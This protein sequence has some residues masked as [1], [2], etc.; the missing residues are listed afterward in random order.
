MYFSL[1]L[2]VPRTNKRSKSNRFRAFIPRRYTRDT[3]LRRDVFLLL[4]LFRRASGVQSF[5]LFSTNIVKNR[6]SRESTSADDG[7]KEKPS[8]RKE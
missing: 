4:L 3:I 7:V 5:R 1:F 6:S 2:G 8:L